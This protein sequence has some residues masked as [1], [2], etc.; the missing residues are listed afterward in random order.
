[1]SALFNGNFEKSDGPEGFRFFRTQGVDG[2]KTDERLARSMEALGWSW[3]WNADERC[4]KL[5]APWLM[6]DLSDGK[7]L[8]AVSLAAK[9]KSLRTEFDDDNELSDQ[10]KNFIR[11]FNRLPELLINLLEKIKQIGLPIP[12]IMP[13]GIAFKG[14]W[15]SPSVVLLDL[16]WNPATKGYVQELIRAKPVSYL[17]VNGNPLESLE[18]GADN[19]PLM[20]SRCLALICAQTVEKAKDP[21]WCESRYGKN[22]WKKLVGFQSSAPAT[23]TLQDLRTV[24]KNENLCQVFGYLKAVVVEPPVPNGSSGRKNSGW[25]SAVAALIVLSFIGIGTYSFWI[26]KQSIND[27]PP[28]TPEP[29]GVTT[30]DGEKS[31]G[32]GGEIVNG[33]TPHPVESTSPELES[34]YQEAK[35]LLEQNRIRNASKAREKLDSILKQKADLEKSDKGKAMLRKSEL[36]KKSIEE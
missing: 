34:V 19:I 12:A 3:A 24:L 26:T 1:M 21:N 16:G 17:M 29:P 23:K 36:L 14:S 32:S 6:D 10:A 18:M 35:D 2:S 22:L 15:E 27:L 7:P 13:S 20:V 31:I 5:V 28:T 9:V 25:F 30:L 11:L 4:G 33:H 8:T